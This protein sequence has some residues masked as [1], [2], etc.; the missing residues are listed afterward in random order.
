VAKQKVG[1]PSTMNFC[2]VAYPYDAATRF[3]DARSTQSRLKTQSY[4]SD[5]AHGAATGELDDKI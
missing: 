4:T 5:F 3:T 2:H 1:L